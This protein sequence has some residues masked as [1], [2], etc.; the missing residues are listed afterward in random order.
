LLNCVVAAFVLPGISD[1]TL[2]DTL[3]CEA[4]EAA[5]EIAAVAH[6]ARTLAAVTAAVILALRVDF[7]ATPLVCTG[8]AVPDANPC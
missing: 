6:T 5:L 7:I 2:I 1:A 4:A 8:S 3:L